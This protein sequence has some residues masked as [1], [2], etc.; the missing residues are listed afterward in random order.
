[1]F[2]PRSCHPWKVIELRARWSSS[3][4]LS[5]EDIASMLSKPT[6]SVR[7]LLSQ[8]SEASTTPQ[9]TPQQLRHLLRLSALPEPTS[10]EEEAEMLKTLDSQLHFVKEVQRVNTA[11]I[12]PL[13]A[14]R[15]E[16]PEAVGE[17]TIHLEDLKEAFAKEKAMGRNGRIKREQS[18]GSKKTE[19]EEWDP[20]RYASKTVGR[21]FVVQKGRD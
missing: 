17:N 12:E 8:P 18:L 15:D 21:Y 14:I 1:M 19:T 5:K 16:T 11:G 3:A 9:V 4:N 13:R 10:K 2:V 7:A 20:L 6:W